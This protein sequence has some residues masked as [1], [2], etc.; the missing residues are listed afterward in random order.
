ML[1]K[2]VG[3][4]KVINQAKADSSLDMI[5]DRSVMLPFS[6]TNIIIS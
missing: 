6:I 2:E 4:M 1:S 3:I 5:V